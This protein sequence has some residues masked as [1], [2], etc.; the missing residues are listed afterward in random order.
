M[1]AATYREHVEQV[2]SYRQNVDE[3]LGVGGGGINHYF[4][5][6][7]SLKFSVDFILKA[8]LNPD[9]PSSSVQ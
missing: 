1:Y 7:E 4:L 8:H 3:R 6:P 2:N 9:S 5:S